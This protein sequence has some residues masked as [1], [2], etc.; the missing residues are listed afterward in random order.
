MIRSTQIARLDG[1]SPSPP[2]ASPTAR[3]WSA[4][5]DRPDALRI[6]RRRAGMPRPRPR[7]EGR[8]RLTR[9]TDGGDTRGGQGAG[10]AGAAEA[11]AE[12]GGP[13]EH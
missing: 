10:A 8:R 1:T 6:R 3:A 13:G 12:L 7:M 4:D 11:H 9:D 2:R 5:V